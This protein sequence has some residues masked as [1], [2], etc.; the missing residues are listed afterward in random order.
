MSSERRQNRLLPKHELGDKEGSSDDTNESRIARAPVLG[1]PPLPEAI[2]LTSAQREELDRRLD[3]LD[4][5]GPTGI[6]WK[7]V[8]RR[9]RSRTP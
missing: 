3:D 6:P 2:P 9:I 4:R 7:E 5:D 1:F 8:V